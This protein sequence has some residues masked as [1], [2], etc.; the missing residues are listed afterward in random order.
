VS[1]AEAPAPERAARP[2]RLQRIFTA[3]SRPGDATRWL[4]VGLGLLLTQLWLPPGLLGV[5]L[6]LLVLVGEVPFLLLLWHGDGARWKRWTWLYGLLHFGLALHWLEEV[7]WFQLLGAALILAPVTVLLGLVLRVGARRGVPFVPLVGV[8]VVLEELLRTVW[9]GGMPW[10]QRALGLASVDALRA[11]AALAGA[12]GLSFLAGTTS[13]WAAGVV[14]LVRARADLQPRLLG[15]LALA[16]AVP[17]LWALLLLVHGAGRI[18]HVER[19]R[20]AREIGHTPLV[21]AV[22]AAIPQSLKHT[23]DPDAGN[24]IFN[25]HTTLTQVGLERARQRPEGILAVLWPETMIPWPFLSPGLLERFPDEWPNHVVV[26]GRLRATVPDGMKP[27]HFLVGGI[28]LF[29]EKPGAALASPEAYADHDS[30]FWIDVARAPRLE[31][32]PPPRPPATATDLPYVLQ[33][34]DKVVRVPG[35]E[36]TPMED[37]FPFLRAWRNRLSQIP[38]IAR[39]A[40]DQEPFALWRWVTMDPAGE[41]RALPVRAGTVICFEVAFPARCR[42]WRRAGC[43]VLLNASNYGWFGQTAFRAQIRA[44]AALRAAELAM[45]VA[46]AGNTG[47]TVFFDPTGAAYGR[48]EPVEL[49]REGNLVETGHPPAPSI[50]AASDEATHRTGFVLAPL[51]VDPS[52]TAYARYGD[53][54]WFV[55]AGLLTLLAAFSGR[56]RPP[57]DGAPDTPLSTG[58]HPSEAPSGASESV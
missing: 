38:E 13:A 56:R 33:R 12:Y 2:G 16:A 53:T 45:T 22:Q 25:P 5:H 37:V 7:G 49:D 29:E 47:P 58:E 32:P 39:G 43:Q 54:P 15:R 20:L 41:V 34:H 27:P 14:G 52:T 36:Y 9:F 3:W 11:G 31:D 1:A 4:L 23:P 8:A 21:L 35:G 24:L 6:P 42:A 55:L 30:L 19:G 40:D 57:P 50:D 44:V 48:F 28:H 46:M 10:P 51:V 18:A 17:A 26:A